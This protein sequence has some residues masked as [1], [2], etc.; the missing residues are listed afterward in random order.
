MSID[1]HPSSGAG[2]HLRGRGASREVASCGA[3]QIVHGERR[4]SSVPMYALLGGEVSNAGQVDY[5][6][7]PEIGCGSGSLDRLRSPLYEAPTVR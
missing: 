3:F 1:V 4:R 7:D 5:V 6:V 2:A